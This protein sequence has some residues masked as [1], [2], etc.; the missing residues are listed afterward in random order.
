[1]RTFVPAVLAIFLLL[2]GLAVAG[3]FADRCRVSDIENPAIASPGV[4]PA[5]APVA[6]NGN[7]EKVPNFTGTLRVYM[8]EPDSRYYDYNFYNYQNGFLDFAVNQSISIPYQDS[9]VITKVWNGATAGFSDITEGNIGAVAAV[10]NSTG[11]PANSDPDG[12]AP[13]TAYYVDACAFALSGE[14]VSD[15]AIDDYTHTVLV[16]EGTAHG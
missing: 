8:V 11:H 5:A 2:A 7:G 12:A 6:N 3:D 14:T 4:T 15:T 13:F 1:M 9:I 16:E 10:F